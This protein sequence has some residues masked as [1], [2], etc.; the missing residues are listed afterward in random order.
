M[1]AHKGEHFFALINY[2]Q[3]WINYD[4]LCNDGPEIITYEELYMLINKNFQDEGSFINII[5]ASNQL[6]RK[7]Q[8]SYRQLLPHQRI[9]NYNQLLETTENIKVFRESRHMEAQK[10]IRSNYQKL[11][12]V[13]GDNELEIA[14]QMS[15]KDQQPKLGNSTLE[16][17]E[18]FM[19]Q[20]ALEESKKDAEKSKKQEAHNSMQIQVHI[21]KPNGKFVSLPFNKHESFRNLISIMSEKTGY[22]DLK[23]YIKSQNKQYIDNLD[24]TLET[25]LTSQND[26]IIFLE[27]NINPFF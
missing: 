19:L 7:H 10:N 23:A 27:T 26:R 9:F 3:V 8:Q 16:L 5:D 1:I 12:G 20:Q 13:S 17:E 6:P 14:I 25:M 11:Y 4:S 24:L 21:C 2:N 22:D 15:L 18:E